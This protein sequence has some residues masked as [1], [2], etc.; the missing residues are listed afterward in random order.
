LDDPAGLGAGGT[1]RG[2][3]GR[4]NRI[5]IGDFV[6]TSPVTGFSMARQGAFATTKTAGNIGG[7]LLKRFK[8]IFDYPRN[9][10]I[11][12]KNRSLGLPDRY[13]MSGMVL[14][15]EEL[16]I[17]VYH[18]MGDSPAEESGI[19]VGDKILEI[20]DHSVGIYSLQQIRDLLKQE[21]GTKIILKIEARRI[22]KEVQLVLRELIR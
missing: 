21:E 12:E 11:L 5:R 13:D 3:I 9:Q 20:N 14:V 16:M 18:V 6:I 19:K 7:G 22:V 17:R 8:V 4:I 2:K 15:E 10:M 1:T